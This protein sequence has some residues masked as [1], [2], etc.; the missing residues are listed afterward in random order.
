MKKLVVAGMLG[1]AACTGLSGAAVS[2]PLFGAGVVS[3]R[4]TLNS[5]S[6]SSGFRPMKPIG[7]SSLKNR[8]GSSMAVS[9][10]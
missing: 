7:F 10:K 6:R 5:S 3:A 9:K 1:L 8:S 2:G 4:S